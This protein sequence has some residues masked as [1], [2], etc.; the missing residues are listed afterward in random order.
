MRSVININVEK[1]VSQD[2][3]EHAMKTLKST[4]LS[5]E[6]TLI[7]EKFHS[8][9]KEHYLN[10]P[11]KTPPPPDLT[12]T[13]SSLSLDF[14]LIPFPPHSHR[15]LYSKQSS[16]FLTQSRLTSSNPFL[17]LLL[18][19]QTLSSLED[20]SNDDEEHTIKTPK[21]PLSAEETSVAEKL[22]SLIKDHHR[23]SANKTLSPDPAYT[24]PS[25]SLDFSQTIS[26]V[27]SISPSI[28][29]HVIEQS[30]GVR[31]GIPVPQVLA[32]FQLG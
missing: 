18:Q 23:N 6:E 11:G 22:H 24:I 15:W 26:T 28:I 19:P 14:S 21:T 17:P 2:E 25:L 7:A 1:I 30:G 20:D 12:Y 10:H 16:V 29:R 3:E 27:H 13:V 9:I 5:P 4:A 8:L 32:F 31:H